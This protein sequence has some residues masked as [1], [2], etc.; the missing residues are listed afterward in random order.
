MPI[1]ED[2]IKFLASQVMDDVPEGGGAA[3]GNEIIDGQ[4]NN[5]F[6]DISDLDRAY[7]R[8]NLRKLFLAVRTLSTDLYGGAKT[9][10]TALPQDE[11]IGYTLFSTDDAFDTRTEAVSRVEAYLFKGPMWHGALYENHIVGMRQISVIQRPNT[12]IPPIGKTLTLVQDEGLSG[13]KEQYV[14]VIDIDVTET[15]FSEDGE[16]YLAWVVSMSLSDALRFDFTGHTPNKDF[17]YSYT[18]RARLRDTTVADATRYYGSQRLRDAASIGDLSVTA[19]SMFTRLVPSAETE[20][21]LI[22][23]L[24]NPSITISRNAGTRDVQVTQ[25]GQTLATEVTVENRRFNWVTTVAPIPA[26]GTLTVSFMSQGNWYLLQDDGS[27]TISGSDP[28]YGAG[29]VSYTTGTISVTLG[30]LPDAD[31]QIIYIWATPVHY[32]VRAGA[33]A[34]AGAT[35]DTAFT[36]T[37]TPVW[38]GTLTLTWQVNGAPVQAT[39][40]GGVITGTGASGSI[41]YTT[42]EIKLQFTAPPDRGTL[43]NA[44]YEINDGTRSDA[45]SATITGGQFSMPGSSPWANTGG[46][47]LTYNTQLGAVDVAFRINGDGSVTSV[48][49]SVYIMVRRYFWEEQTIGT[50]DSQTGVVTLTSPLQIQANVYSHFSGWSEDISALDPVSASDLSAQSAGDPSLTASVEDFSISLVFDLLTTVADHAVPESIEFAAT[51]KTYIDRSGTIYTDVDPVTGSGTPSGSI[52]YGTG[53]VTLTVWADDAPTGID[54]SSCLTQYGE[55]VAIDGFFRT[56]AAPLKS[57]SL[58]LIATTLDGEQITATADPDGLFTADYIQGSVNYNI[59]TAA[60]TFGSWVLEST[61][62]D[63]ERAEDW[64][65]PADIQQDGTIYKP[66]PVIPSTLRYNAVSFTYIPLDA[67]IL[68]IDPVRLPA[69]GRVPIYR[70]GNVILIKHTADAAPETIADGGTLSAGRTRLAWVRLLDANGATVSGD[71]Y[72]L[73][74]E[75]GT[76]TVPDVTGLVQPLTLRHTVADLRLATDAQ[77]NGTVTLSRPLSHD[78][79]ADESLVASCL[80]HGDRRARVS[81]TWDQSS[82]DG[83]WSDTPG[84]PATATLNLIDYPITVTNE[85]CDT[86]RWVLRFLSSATAELISEKRGLVW[87]GSYTEG[88]VDI[89]PVNPRTKDADGVGTP[90]MVIPGAANGGGWSAGNVVRINTIGAI[91]DMWM[92]RAIQQS[93]E[94]MD[95]GADGCEIYAL[96][97]ID[98]P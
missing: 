30:A 13:E 15:T 81:A 6:E 57:E 5:V 94:P 66:R 91:A 62:T 27:G 76:V 97:N 14:R 54:V 98:R 92:A 39:D 70:P 41:N 28:S 65:D 55:W 42:G 25:Q 40:N 9:V 7:G 79:P 21:P 3:T 33:S 69:D 86:D 67:T 73:D 46:G 43:I 45:V 31:S 83:T 95:D 16:E 64:Y 50:F 44:A 72:T 12:E 82:W 80:I 49:G 1:Q 48:A 88:G 22:D 52:D 58:Q 10:V 47:T 61:L 37:D 71:L 59:G 89:A 87:S 96:G 29:T 77:I 17:A 4:M 74:R 78:Y 26:P 56:A 53:R 63:D 19:D 24:L 36:L 34:D 8:F 85:G 68:G 60:V 75:N 90:Y 93:D 32:A 35:L 38:P 11:A 23:Q 2:N 20:T 51:G 18:G 84:T